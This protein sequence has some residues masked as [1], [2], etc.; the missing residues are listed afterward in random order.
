MPLEGKTLYRFSY[1]GL[2]KI[3]LEYPP[4]FYEKRKEKARKDGLNASIA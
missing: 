4:Y 1:L 3:S 2:F